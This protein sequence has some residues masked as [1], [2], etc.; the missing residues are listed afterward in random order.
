MLHLLIV[1]LEESDDFGF[2]EAL[3]DLGDCKTWQWFL[4][5]IMKIPLNIQL[6][7]LIIHCCF[8]RH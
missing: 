4:I 2:T 5:L 3:S 1:R 8:S 6:D 7:D